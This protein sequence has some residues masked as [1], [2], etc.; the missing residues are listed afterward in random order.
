MQL[1]ARLKAPSSTCPPILCTRSDQIK[2][3]MRNSY[4]AC[5]VERGPDHPDRALPSFSSLDVVMSVHS[6]C[7]YSWYYNERSSRAEQ[8]TFCYAGSSFPLLLASS[9]YVVF[10]FPR[11]HPASSHPRIPASRL[12]PMTAAGILSASICYPTQSIPITP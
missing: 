2:R 7:Y 1:D 10:L 6:C 4:P 8:Y 9:K 3:Q 12:L 5:S 11:P